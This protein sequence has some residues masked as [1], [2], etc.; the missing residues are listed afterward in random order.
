[1]N[2]KAVLILSL[3][4]ILALLMEPLT[5]LSQVIDPE[6]V[7]LIHQDRSN[8]KIAKKPKK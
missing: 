7:P 1:M 2:M 8:S 5:A 4:P 6:P 3:I